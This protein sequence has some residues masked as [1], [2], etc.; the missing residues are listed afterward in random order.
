MATSDRTLITVAGV[1]CVVCCLPL[2]VAA[3]P[4]VAIGG[5]LAATAGVAAQVVRKTRRKRIGAEPRD[6]P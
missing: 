4:A 3:G 5:A 1:A 6:N 2:I